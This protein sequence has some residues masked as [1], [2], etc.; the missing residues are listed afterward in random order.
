MTSRLDRHGRVALM[1]RDLGFWPLACM[2][3]GKKPLVEFADAGQMT[4]DDIAREWADKP[5]ANVAI[6]PV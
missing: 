6:Q 5:E 2:P 1:Y 3:N 4:G